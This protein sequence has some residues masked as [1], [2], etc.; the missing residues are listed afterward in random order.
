MTIQIQ[1]KASAVKMGKTVT[2]ESEVLVQFVTWEQN[3][4]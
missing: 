3:E 4:L 2:G 1:R